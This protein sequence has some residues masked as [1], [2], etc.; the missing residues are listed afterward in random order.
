MK[1]L[2]ILLF[3]LLMISSLILGC[4]TSKTSTPAATTTTSTSTTPAVTTTTTPT[5][6]PTITAT[7]TPTTIPAETPKT[8]G[9]LKMILWA[10]PSGTGG[11][12]RELFGNDFLSSQ[13]I[14][15]PLLH[16]GSK[17][18]L[19]PCLAE[20]WKVADDLKSITF[21]LRTGV[22][23]HDGT[24]FNAQAAKWN[25]DQTIASK[26]QV[27][28]DSVDIIDDYTI[29]L[30]LNQWSNLIL[31]GLDSTA[32][33]MISPTAFDTNGIDVA[34]NNPVGT[35]PFKFV[36]FERDVSYKA[37]RNPDYWVKGKPYLDAVE[38]YYVGDT[39]TQKAEFQSGGADVLQ[40]EPAKNAADLKALGFPEAV[41]VTSTF[42]L[43]PDTAHPDS[44]FAIKEV[45]EAV[46]YALDRDSIANAFS[47]GFWTAP[48]QIPAPSSTAYNPNYTLARNYNV[49]KAKQ[50]MADAGY[51][52]G[53][54]AT[55]SV[56][57]VGIDRNI[58]VA[59]QQNLAEIGI[60]IEI[61]IPAAI[62]K[63]LGDSNTLQN[64]LILE[65]VFGGANWNGAL[66]L[67]FDPN[68]KFQNGVWQRT[69]EFIDLY[70][71]SLSSKDMDV[72]LI[73]AVVNYI[74]QEALAIPVFNGGSGYAYQSYVKD[75]DW[76]DRGGGWT[77]EDTWLD[78]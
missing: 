25:L 2:C 18:N 33:W 78:K 51:A 71:K 75:A 59:I 77:P 68:M 34:R 26:T 23:F 52:N 61:N 69:A 60:T 58:A 56:I 6:T 72:S 4:G 67:A 28:W 50:L 29:R 12:P 55:L 65:P 64:A 53:F 32:S 76:N 48:N 13:H 9:T 42:C 66:A 11:V 14:I 30:N 45:R 46:E 37:V 38:I 5:S 44:P 10:S 47:Y 21:N 22:K 62:P 31:T 35:G 49:P 70:N 15:E 63:W 54:T 41:T 20:S 57:P 39:M 8:G 19:I 7:P 3:A 43:L 1:R 36:S 24:D 16:V 27:R 74:G 17:G 73:Q 40:I